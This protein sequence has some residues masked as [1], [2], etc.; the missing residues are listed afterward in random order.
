MQ[1]RDFDEITRFLTT[2]GHATLFEYLQVQEDAPNPTV[3]QAIKKRRSWAQGQ[4][5]NPKYRAEALWVIKNQRIMRGALVDDRATYLEQV[6]SRNEERSLE[7]LSLF[8]RGS[9]ASG[10]LS[11]AGE[12]AIFEQGRN[13]GLRESS[14][15]QRLDELVLEHGAAR[16]GADEFV[17]HY[18]ALGVESTATIDEIDQAYRTRY[19]WARN[20]ADKRKARDVYAQLDAALRDLKDP[21]RREDYDKRYAEATGRKAGP[22]EPPQ[23]YL[24]PPPEVTAPRPEPSAPS[25]GSATGGP[26]LAP[27]RT[28]EEDYTEPPGSAPPVKAPRPGSD[29]PVTWV[30]SRGGSGGPVPPPPQR[31]AGKTLSLEA[32]KDG[33]RLELTTPTEISRTV[34]K[35]P[36]QI[37]IGLHQVGSGT[38]TARILAD[39]SWVTVEPS[40]LKPGARDHQVVAT[41]HPSRMPKARGSSVVTV[42][43]SHGPRLAV[44]LEIEQRGGRSPVRLAL[45]ALVVAGLLGGG[46]WYISNARTPPPPQPRSL[47]VRPDPLS[48]NVTI[49]DTIMGEGEVRL[50]D[51]QLPDGPVKVKV[52]LNGFATYEEA[53]FPKP[54][55]P[56]ILAPKLELVAPMDFIPSEGQQAS[57]LE[58]NKVRQTLETQAALFDACFSPEDPRFLSLDGYVSAIGKVEGLKVIDPET[59]DPTLVTCISRGLRAATFIID[60]PEADYWTFRATLRNP[61]RQ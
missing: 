35:K 21:S 34:G 3:E 13:L 54:G 37:H 58:T 8:I 1:A 61:H 56:V 14:V 47:L 29:D 28:S 55:D 44:T 43:P 40:R 49:G 27:A 36:E 41:V 26:R 19:R 33:T 38:V 48:A 16:G 4:Q 6:Q 7:V 42:V 17:D 12:A 25:I 32:Q 9:L 11:E 2:V 39:R 31:F 10:T 52:E 30:S 59:P 22:E 51:A 60:N 57:A 46:A 18:E 45:G 5:A 15:R 20:L 50:N 24:P 53:V 23:A